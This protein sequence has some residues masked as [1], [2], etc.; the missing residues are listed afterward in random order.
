MNILKLSINRQCSGMDALQMYKK[1]RRT[2]MYWSNMKKKK[3][4]AMQ[5]Q[6]SHSHPIVTVLS[7]IAGK[8]CR[9]V[10][11]NFMVLEYNFFL[12]RQRYQQ[13]KVYTSKCV[14]L[15]FSTGFCRTTSNLI[16]KVPLTCSPG[17]KALLAV[18]G[19]V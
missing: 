10:S 8:H 2:A 16:Q 19:V 14:C 7:S 12:F 13:K 11:S 17:I 9:V 5:A 6:L 3:K 1:T 18:S 4:K 15:L